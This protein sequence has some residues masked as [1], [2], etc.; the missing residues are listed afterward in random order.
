L[1][2]LAACSSG[3]RE[4]G[5]APAPVV[6]VAPDA[7]IDDALTRARDAARALGADLM[8][9]LLAEMEEGGPMQAVKVCSEIAQSVAATHSTAG[10][11]VRR[12]S[13]RVRNPAD[14]PDDVEREALLELEALHDEGRLPGEWVRTED[15]PAGRR[16]R[17]LK[18]ITILPAC[19]ACHGDLVELEPDVR[20]LLAERYPDDRA[21]G[22]AAGDLRGA[23]SVSVALH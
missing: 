3:G 6:P 11:T 12:V 17:F 8:Q 7:A 16:L 18:P 14:A 19:L 2:L 5:E 4:G 22:Y 10:L 21:F 13:L 20:R 1:L 23:V 9:R 15:G